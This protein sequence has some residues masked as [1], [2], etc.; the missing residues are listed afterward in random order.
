MHL[1]KAIGH[2][3]FSF[4]ATFAKK[5]SSKI[6]SEA[7]EKCSEHIIK[8]RTASICSVC[9]ANSAQYF[10]GS[11]AL[12][13]HEDCADLLIPCFPLFDNMISVIEGFSKIV[14]F[15]SG[16]FERGQLKETKVTNARKKEKISK[17]KLMRIKGL[18]ILLEEYKNPSISPSEYTKMLEGICGAFFTLTKI[19]PIERI[20]PMYRGLTNLLMDQ[21]RSIADFVNNDGERDLEERVQSVPSSAIPSDIETTISSP[22]KRTSAPAPN[23]NWD[24]TTTSSS[25]QTT[26]QDAITLSSTFD[27]ETSLTGDITFF[28]ESDNMFESYDGAKGTTL[29]MMSRPYT[30]MNLSCTFP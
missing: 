21:A 3:D 13:T 20:S 28:S 17:N 30:P 23:S 5:N 14:S 9:S 6:L 24:S 11:K 26:Q 12:I 22:T 4:L 7:V 8:V 29:D 16:R 1:Q 10:I 25:T 15:I 27:S 19:S 18:Q 2:P